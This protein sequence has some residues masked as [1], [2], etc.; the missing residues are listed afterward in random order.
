[1]PSVGEMEGAA[2]GAV[3]EPWPLVGRRPEVERALRAI[4]DPRTSGT[5]VVGGP[6][7]GKTRL[8]DEVIAQAE[9]AG[10][11]V[12]RATASESARALPL[13]ALAHL[14][15]PDAVLAEAEGGPL[16]P[17]RLLAHARKAVAGATADRVVLAIDDVQHLDA[18]SAAL[19]AQLVAEGTVALLLTVRAGERLPDTVA[20]F[21]RAER[22]VTVE[23]APLPD[24]AVDT[25]LH[26]GLGAPVEG[27]TSAGFRVASTGNP[28]VL[29]ELVR[30]ALAD[31]HL[32]LRDGVWVLDGP[33]PRAR[34]ATELLGT[35]LDHL[36]GPAKAVVEVL[37]LAGPTRLDVVMS[38]TSIDV[39]E[40][41]EADE[42]IELRPGVD[43]DHDLLAISHPLLVEAV[44]DQTSPLRARSILGAHAD[45]VESIAGVHGD[46]AVQVAT[47]RLDAGAAVDPVLLESAAVLARYA[48]DLPLTAR[49]ASAAERVRPTLRAGVLH[50][51]ALH[52]LARWNESEAV[53]AAAS[54]RHGPL[55]DRV[56][57]VMARSANLLFGLMELD[58]ARVVVQE[59]LA[60]VGAGGHDADDAA[61]VELALFELRGRL[62]V[63]EVY[64]GHPSI[65]LELLGPQ[66]PPPTAP[67]GSGAVEQRRA[68]LRRRAVWAMGGVPALNLLCRTAE[69]AEVARSA[70]AEH[71]ELG[72]DVGFPG[73][74]SH[75][76]ALT[77]TMQ[78]HGD[79]AMAAQLAGAGYQGAVMAGAL[80]AQVW[81]AL[82]LGRTALVQGHASS[83]ERWFRE[84]LSLCTSAAWMGPRGMA[85][86]GLAAGT[87]LGGDLDAASRAVADFQALDDTFRFLQPE[88]CLGP[89][90]LAMAAG[91]HD[92]ARTHLRSGAEAAGAHEQHGTEA[93]LLH[94]L[95][96]L[97]DGAQVV[98]RL[99]HLEVLTTSPLVATRAAHVRAELA[100]DPAGLV[101]VAERFE[102]MGCDL[103]SAEAFAAAAD[104]VR[105]VG[106]QRQANQLAARAAAAMER[107]Q[108]TRSGRVLP[109]T[110][111]VPLS[112]REREIAVL[113]ASGVPSKDIAAQLFVSVRTV[114]NH[115]QNV[116]TKL[117]VSGR[118]ELRAALDGE[119]AS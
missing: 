104:V 25:L 72:N 45:R 36:D 105:S 103:A 111:V 65:A 56:A 28:L 69:A 15:P 115:L 88:R 17:V 68:E 11:R 80:I 84:S 79:L 10:H 93:W 107:C 54:D 110:T 43:G 27:R 81:F 77:H 71:T 20:G 114:N 109:A 62:A 32:V 57:L 53:L 75:L 1:M 113:A 33:M 66:P 29:R 40:A 5:V 47:W 38:M 51:E 60:A 18:V 90:W 2:T 96:R 83:A 97:G 49:L 21:Q 22:L 70:H 101:E 26:L 31:G 12:L 48:S 16:D 92:E 108:G 67:S 46:D 35:R 8:A 99:N 24:T 9:T 41:L 100:R 116:Y 86:S 52:Q 73:P 59:E 64:D 3:L 23:L 106:D 95:A 61:Q 55:A 37:A 89:A 76:I 98:D 87:A 94:E 6:G 117:G 50:G 34:N 30:S 44:R 118:A 82:H 119:A 19:L 58:R 91:R 78:D 39:L 4:T 102:Q 85:S 42:L 112:P 14:L 74:G 13:G 63:I 7:L